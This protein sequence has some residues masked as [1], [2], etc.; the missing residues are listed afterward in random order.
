MEERV[1][2]KSDVDILGCPPRTYDNRSLMHS[3]YSPQQKG[4]RDNLSN[5]AAVR[6]GVQRQI[7]LFWLRP[8][9][10]TDPSPNKKDRVVKTI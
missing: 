1:G 3:R 6:L 7:G 9:R 4:V 2:K 8:T 5:L 10:G